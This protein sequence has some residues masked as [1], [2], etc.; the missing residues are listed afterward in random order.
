MSQG[1]ITQGMKLLLVED[2]EDDYVLTQGLLEDIIAGEYSLTWASTP[3][4]ARKHFARNNHDLCMM[5]YRLGSEDGLSLLREAPKLGFKGP[6]I[7]LTGQDNKQLDQEALNAG[8]EDYLVKSQLNAQGLARAIRY[9]L[10]R[11]EMEAERVERLRAETENRSKSE[12][13]AHL[14]HELRTPLTAILGY[15]DLLLAADEAPDKNHLQ[16][17][18]RNGRHLL[19]LLNDVLDL[20]KIE[21]GKLEIEQLDVHLHSFVNEICSLISVNAQDKNL[22]LNVL[23]K[24]AL[25]VKIKTDPTRLRQ[26]LL[27]LLGN[28][29]KFTEEGEVSLHIAE[30]Q[31]R[32]KTYLRFSIRDTGVGISKNDIERLFKPFTQVTNTLSS[33][34]QGTGLGLAI[35]RQLAQCLGGNISVKSQPGVGSVFTLYINPGNLEGI[36]RRPL[37][38]RSTLDVTT[39]SKAFSFKGHVLVTDDLPDIRMLLGHLITSFGG[40]VTYASDGQEAIDLVQRKAADGDSFD[41]LIMD[42]QM[43][44]LDGLSATRLLRD[45]GYQKPI[46]ALTAASLRGERERCL[47]A[48]C[49]DYLSKPIDAATLLTRIQKLLQQNPQQPP[50]PE[51]NKQILLVEDNQDAREATAMLLQHLGWQV[52]AVQ[53]GAEALEVFRSLQPIAVLLDINLPDM[54]GYSL[55]ARLREAGLKDAQLIALSGNQPDKQRADQAGFDAHLVKPLDLSALNTALERATQPAI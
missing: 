18:K 30:T 9:A 6:I 52:L 49:D 54:D 26:I 48:G 4:E 29:I 46:L 14:S 39:I 15:T 35:S 32:N 13:L 7:M 41:L 3:Q 34:Q 37:D 31:V 2:D 47:A 16:I 45:Q 25:P 17:I 27:N 11:R 55:A 12:F 53:T 51:P 33:R 22:R 5:D 24:T 1:L 21:A 23:A 36:E 40:R 50:K 28:A 42:S 44:V 8:A 38:S 19:S 20:S 43:P 10:T